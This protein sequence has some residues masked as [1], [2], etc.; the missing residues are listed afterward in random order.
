MKRI[1]L[2]LAVVG[3]VSVDAPAARINLLE[4]VGPG[5]RRATR[6][7]QTPEEQRRQPIRIE[8]ETATQNAVTNN[9]VSNTVKAVAAP[10][11]ETKPVAEAKP[12]AETKPVVEAKKTAVPALSLI[13]A[14]TLTPT[15][16]PTPVK[17]VKASPVVV[18]PIVMT[19]F[20]ERVVTNVIDRV[21]TNFVNRIATNYVDR[22]AT[23]YVDRVA[24]NF[25]DR[26]ETN[27]VDRVIDRVATNFV[28]RV[29]TNF[30]ERVVTNVIDHIATNYVD[31]VATNFVD[32]VATNYIDRVA[33][34]FVD[35]VATNFVD[36][37]ATN[38]V[39]RIVTNVIER[40]V[41]NDLSKVV[42]TNDFGIVVREPGP[43]R[44]TSNKVYYDRKEGYAVFTGKV[45]VDTEEYQMHT[46]KAYVFFE[47]T[48]ELRRIVASGGVA[49][50]NGL[51][52][53]YGSRASYYRNSG[54]V[55]L[56]GDDKTIAEVIDKS[57]GE[58]QAV[59]GSKIKFWTMS[60]QVEVLDARISSP[61]SGGMEI[62]RAHV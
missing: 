48:N 50:T 32:R 22:V 38:F 25:V 10:V 16:P 29:A 30:V 5:A 58:D 44:I 49:I 4:L 24:T 3:L 6:S 33:T 15:N 40:V 53:A 8:R 61:V 31:R 9:V 14:E 26:V 47:G 60:E 54:M 13:A 35:R 59:R 37:I 18:S 57:K 42:A 56:Y 55:I 28:D 17:E 43:P 52:R 21:A 51:K 46:K 7:Q 39:D 36:R 1:F 27:F 62:G 19:N 20:V 11:A 45:H 41:T 12:I 2:L 34:N 23:N